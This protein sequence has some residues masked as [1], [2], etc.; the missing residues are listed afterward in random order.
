MENLASADGVA[1]AVERLVGDAEHPVLVERRT[2]HVRQSLLLAERVVVGRRDED[3]VVGERPVHL[4]V[5]GEESAVDGRFRHRNEV[6]L[7]LDRRGS[8]P[9]VGVGCHVLSVATAALRTH[10]R[11]G[12]AAPAPDAHVD[13]GNRSSTRTGR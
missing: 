13:S 5:G 12:D 8:E 7:A 3:A 4:A 9:F 2:R 10:G 1:P 11:S 6:R